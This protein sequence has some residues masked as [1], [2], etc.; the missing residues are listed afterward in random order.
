M[1][2]KDRGKG[3]VEPS[4]NEKKDRSG[5]TKKPENVKIP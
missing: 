1:R 3:S 4:Y 2:I 5:P